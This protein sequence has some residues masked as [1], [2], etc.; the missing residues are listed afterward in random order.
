MIDIGANLSRFDEHELKK[1]LIRAD[2]AGISKIIAT[3]T[4]LDSTYT[5]Q[6]I[7]DT[8]TEVYFSAGCHPHAARHWQTIDLETMDRFFRNPKCVFAGETGLDYH[9]MISTKEEQIYAFTKQIEL[10]IQYNL[11]LFLH[12]RRAH[13]DF[14]DIL[15]SYKDKL[16]PVIVH[17][18]TG[19][20]KEVAEYVSRG[21]WLGITGWLCDANRNH[22]LAE[23]VSSIPDSK[24]LVE[25]DTPYLAPKGEWLKHLAYPLTSANGKHAQNEPFA[26]PAVIAA[27]AHYRGQTFEHILE[28]TTKN[29]NMFIERRLNL[30]MPEFSNPYGAPLY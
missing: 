17:C 11:P 12:E 1:L 9:R 29:A 16:P 19:D 27:L 2:S 23:A 5:V 10:A 13:K 30:S 8:H 28:H 4:S 15:D 7:A 18:F 22:Q 14:L 6:K 24:L 25:T 26:L 20:V 3:G 21:Y